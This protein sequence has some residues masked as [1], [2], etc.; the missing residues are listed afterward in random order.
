[1]HTLLGVQPLAEQQLNL[2]DEEAAPALL[3]TALGAA[4]A[5]DLL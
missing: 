5:A 1:M 3:R 2:V 4:A